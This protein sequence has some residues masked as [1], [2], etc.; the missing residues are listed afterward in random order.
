[1]R[2]MRKLSKKDQIAIGLV[3]LGVILVYMFFYAISLPFEWL[4]SCVFA[5]PPEPFNNNFCLEEAHKNAMEKSGTKTDDFF[6]SIL[7]TG[8]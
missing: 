8:V 5:W 6:E 2:V 7:D 3:V 4:K 1:M